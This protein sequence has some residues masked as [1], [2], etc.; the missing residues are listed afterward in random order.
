MIAARSATRSLAAHSWLIAL[1]ALAVF[2]VARMPLGLRA[3]MFLSLHG[4]LAIAQGSLALRVLRSNTDPDF[5]R[6]LRAALWPAALFARVALVFAPV[7]TT[8]DVSRYLWDGAVV[9]S[10]HDPF[11]FAPDAPA[12]AAVRAGFPMPLDHHDVVG[13]YPPLAQALFALCALTGPAL[14]PLAWKSLLA[15]ASALAGRAL[16]RASTT[17]AQTAAASL[18]LFHPLVLFEASVGAHLDVLT[19]ACA[20]FALLAIERERWTRAGLWLGAA[21]AIKLTPVL[22][23]A[24]L[25]WRARAQRARFVL[26]CAL[27]PALTIVAPWAALGLAFP[28]SLPLVAKHWSF[29]A[30]LYSALY[31]RFPWQDH[32]IRPA[33]SALGAALVLAQWLRSRASTAALARDALTGYALTNPTLYPWYLLTPVAFAARAP[34]ALVWALATI[35]P[36]S[37]EL[38]DRYARDRTWTPARWPLWLTAIVPLLVA[39]AWKLYERRE[40]D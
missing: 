40:R 34:S 26:A 17:P 20:I 15:L 22:V 27:A 6:S 13:C 14:A 5:Q 33:L 31:A 2:A 16:L 11:A 29:G 19:G 3:P 9:L 4:L 1:A 21:V 35:T 37:Y 8:T 30:P 28:G 23:C 39:I 10:G 24:A 7:F 25:L 12:L 36:C 38:I 32:V 18:W